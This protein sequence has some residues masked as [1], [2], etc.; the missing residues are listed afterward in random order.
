M[1][2]TLRPHKLQGDRITIREIEAEI[3]IYDER[4]H[5]A[6]CLNPSSAC[7]WQLCDGRNTL[8]EIAAGATKKLGSQVNREL[9]L[10]TLEELQ[11]KGLL[12][13][14]MAE[15]LPRGPSRREMIGK[16]GLAAALLLPA[17]AAIT[18][19]PA[20]AQSGSVGTDARR[21]AKKRP[22]AP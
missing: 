14:G 19:P 9:V 20:M 7:I 17:I 21:R 8:G 2:S 16:V 18:A 10:F 12:E 11:E 6:W 22:P 13:D 1:T 4:T 3:L 15:A 5:R